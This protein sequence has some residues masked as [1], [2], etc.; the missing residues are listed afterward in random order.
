MR[1]LLALLIAAG[2]FVACLADDAGNLYDSRP[3]I[4]PYYFGPNAFPVPEI[5]ER[6]SPFLNVGIFGEYYRGTRKDNTYDLLL[7]TEIPL[8]T[9]RV[10]LSLWWQVMEW[11]HTSKEFLQTADIAEPYREDALTGHR[12]GDI[13]V[14]TLIQ[15]LDENKYR[16]GLTVRAA[17]K[18]ASGGGFNVRRFYDSP[19]YFFDTALCKRFILSSV[20]PIR[21]NCAVSTGFLCWQTAQSVQND[22]IM[23]G[24]KLGVG[25]GPFTLN[26][27][28][29]GYSGWQH[30]D[31]HSG[32]KAFD[33]PSRIQL[34]LSYKIREFI[35]DVKF[36]K[37]I[38]DYPYTGLKIGLLYNF[39]I[40]RH[41]NL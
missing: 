26:G 33:Q 37:G 36:L 11:Y 23:Y 16:P 3:I 15:I 38:H 19:G 17:L 18:T 2:S 8:F 24:I 41:N 6:T 12:S 21:F 28:F 27:E 14:A 22:A 1:R 7:K 5:A 35:L 34:D 20:I 29:G 39:K 4:S 30:A 32:A 25:Y 10:N 40:L 9:P 13:Y 31:R